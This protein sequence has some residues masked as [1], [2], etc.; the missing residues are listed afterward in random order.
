VNERLRH[1]RAGEVP[2]R[3]TAVGARHP[4]ELLFGPAARPHPRRR[5]A[6]A[7][8]RSDRNAGEGRFIELRTLIGL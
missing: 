5:G 8:E 3:L 7:T 2:I 6:A 1:R 4:Q